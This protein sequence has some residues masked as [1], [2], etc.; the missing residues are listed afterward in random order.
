MKKHFISIAV[1][2][3]LFLIVH[4]DVFASP[5]MTNP[6]EPVDT[7]SPRATLESFIENSRQALLAY[8]RGDRQATEEFVQRLL[9]CLNLDKELPDLKEAIGFEAIIYIGE[10]LH[11]VEIPPYDTIPDKK[12]VTEKNITSWAIPH[13]QIVIGLS[14][15]G[16]S[17]GQFLFTP[18][19][20]KRSSEFYNKVKSLPYKWGNRSGDVYQELT[21]RGGFLISRAFASEFSAWFMTDLFGLRLWQWIGLVFFVIGSSVLTLIA[22]IYGRRAL[23]SLDRKHELGLEHNIG[24]LILP[25]ALIFFP[26]IGLRFMVYGLHIFNADIYR[27]VAFVLLLLLYLGGI[28]F[29]VA[30]LNRLSTTVIFVGHFDKSGMDTQLIRLGFQILALIITSI[31]A[32]DFGHRLGLPTYSMVTGLGIGGL[33][34]ALAGREALSNLIGTIMIIFDQPFK[35]GDYIVVGEGDEGTVTDVGFRSTRIRTRDGILISIPNSTVANMKIVNQSAPVTTSR[36]QLPVSVAYGSHPKQVEEALLSAVRKNPFVVS[37]PIP[38]VR[39]TKFADSAINFTL[40]CWINRPE[41]R[42]RTIAQLNLDIY[43]EFQKRNIVMPF[44]Q[45]DVHVV[46]KEGQ[47]FSVLDK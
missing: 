14:A 17:K 6:L 32:I 29:I 8:R 3:V 39:L 18:E 30:I 25:M 22:Y 1:G 21:S 19:T 40:L 34:V 26:K 38:F 33:A 7:S 41:F 35:P 27:P 20:V 24:G 13:T 9:R 46:L 31:L 42:G 12:T 45:R 44:P 36:I 11:R 28:W 47:N 43:E 5:A 4:A 15:E 16:S 23:R 10:T 2:V 37:H